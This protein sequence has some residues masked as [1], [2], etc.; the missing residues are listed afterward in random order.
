MKNEECEYLIK[1]D[2]ILCV[3]AQEGRDYLMMLVVLPIKK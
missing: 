1:A 3:T 2:K